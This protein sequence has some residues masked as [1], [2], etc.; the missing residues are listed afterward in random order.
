MQQLSMESKKKSYI[1][2]L[3]AH[4]FKW[5]ISEMDFSQFAGDLSP[6][7]ISYYPSEVVCF[8]ALD[9]WVS[10]ANTIITTK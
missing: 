5:N 6:L 8:V 1:A 3:T 4:W 7:N 2:C 9:A 10:T